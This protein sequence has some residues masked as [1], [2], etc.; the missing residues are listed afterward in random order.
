MKRWRQLLLYLLLNIL[1]STITVLT[2]LFLWENTD[3]KTAFLL[4]N[5]ESQAEAITGPETTPLPEASEMLIEITDVTGVGNLATERLR[6]TRVGGDPG[7]VV[8]M[9]NWRIRDEDNHEFNISSRS[10]LNSLDL[11]SGGAIDIYTKSGASTPIELYL[12]H[13][14]PLWSQGEIVTLLDGDGSI[15]DTFVIP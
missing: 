15:Q 11:H 12:G 13:D 8:S 9:L 10:G 2:V 4:D 3:L 14:E 1:V 7:E 5:A 6:V